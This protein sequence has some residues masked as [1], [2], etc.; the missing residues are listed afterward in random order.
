VRVVNLKCKGNS[1]FSGKNDQAA[2]VGALKDV[3]LHNGSGKPFCLTYMS[4][5]FVTVHQQLLN[6][7][8]GKSGLIEMT[9]VGA[10]VAAALRSL[11]GGVDV[12]A[13]F[14]P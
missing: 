4:T 5:K 11:E 9:I 3:S 6:I 10:P 2:I 8:I 1:N 14:L 13:D 12:C 7:L